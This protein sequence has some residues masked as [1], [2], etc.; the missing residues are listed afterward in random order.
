MPVIDFHK[1]EVN[2]KVVYYGPGLSGKTTNIQYIHEQIKSKFKG[3]L[4]SL[5]TQTDRTLFFDFLPV[6]L[7][8]MGGY[9]IRMHLYTVP[10]QVHYNATRKLVLKGVDGIV[11]VA[12]SQMTMKD[13][14]IESI[15]NL[16]KNLQSHGKELKSLPHLIQCNKR[17][18]ENL[19]PISTIKHLLNRYGMPMTEAVATEGTGVLET[20][21]EVVKLVVREA[22]DDLPQNGQDSQTAETGGEAMHNAAPPEPARASTPVGESPVDPHSNTASRVQPVMVLPEMAEDEQIEEE[23]DHN[24]AQE[25]AGKPE[26]AGGSSADGAILDLDV[27]L[28]EGGKLHLKLALVARVLKSTRYGEDAEDGRKIELYVKPIQTKAEEPVQPV[29]DRPGENE[30]SL[31]VPTAPVSGEIPVEELS[32]PVTA[33]APRYDPTFHELDIEDSSQEEEKG[34][35]PAGKKGRKGLLGLFRKGR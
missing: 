26:S 12:D 21:R 33:P 5:A 23:A 19:M 17:D 6:D 9:K 11:F 24:Q 32:E 7:G 13:A 34:S 29:Q 1:K 4:V 31:D 10:G 35:G 22:R 27:P 8:E 16:E 2:F 14:N 18:L 15:L 3:K 28:P 30:S 25:A 20:L